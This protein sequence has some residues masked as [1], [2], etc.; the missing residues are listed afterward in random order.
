MEYM[1]PIETAK[2]ILNGESLSEEVVELEETEEVSSVEEDFVSSLLEDNDGDED[3]DE[4]D[5]DEEDED[6]DE[7]KEK[8]TKSEGKLPPWLDKKG[9]NGKKK[10]DD[11]DDD[12]D[13]DDEDVKEGKLP[14]W[15]DKKKSKN[16]KKKSDDDDDDDEEVKESEVILDVDDNQD[17]EGKKATPTPKGTKG[18]K[19]PKAKPSKASGKIDTIKATKEHIDI[20]FAGEEL[21]ED[22]KLKATTIFETAINEKVSAV[23][24]ELLEEHAKVLEEHTQA[25]TDELSEKLDDYVGYVVEQWMQENSLQIESGIKSD[26]SESFLVGLKNLFEDHYVDIPDEKYDILEELQN[27]ISSLEETLEQELE[28]NVSLRKDVLESKCEE[29]FNYC[30]NGMVDTDVD[31]FRKLSEGIEFE[32]YEQYREKINIIKENYFGDNATAEFEFE[33]KVEETTNLSESM[34]VYSSFIGQSEKIAKDN[35]L[36]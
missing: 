36:S 22:F 2:R 10:S 24:E 19:D 4:D 7:V 21:T 29:V 14:P 28:S 11:E 5:D 15:L 16:G 1:D 34:S 25:I 23:E 35:N 30:S 18:K 27:K 13:D 32:D 20:L 6:E 33:G 31:K 9:K 8:K 26:V 17:A 3:E 12:D